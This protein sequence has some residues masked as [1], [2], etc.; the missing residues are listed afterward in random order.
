MSYI[1]EA[2]LYSSLGLS[3]FHLDS[4]SFDLNFTL[5][6]GVVTV[7][8][9]LI[10][11]SFPILAIYLISGCKLS[12][13]LNEISVVIF[14][15]IIRGAIAYGLCLKI[16]T[17]NA[18]IIQTTVLAVVLGTVVILGGLLFLFG[19]I[20]KV[21]KLK[22]KAEDD[23]GEGQELERDISGIYMTL[24][25]DEKKKLGCWKKFDNEKLKKFFGGK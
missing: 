17:E 18:Q 20:V 10:S 6:V 14:G 9:R 25:D 11:V 22:P 5:M 4:P 24:G 7:I 13:K 12:L 3:I 15:G 16:E 8:S 2:V 19:V 21:I 23:E 1:A